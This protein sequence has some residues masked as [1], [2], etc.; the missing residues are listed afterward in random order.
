MDNDNEFNYSEENHF[1]A[2]KLQKNLEVLEKLLYF[3]L[4]LEY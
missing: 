1:K 2:P 3:H 4:S